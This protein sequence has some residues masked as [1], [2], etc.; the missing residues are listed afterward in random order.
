MSIT[1]AMRIFTLGS[2]ALLATTAAV[3]AAPGQP[4]PWQLGLQDAV[5]PVAREGTA[6]FNLL[7]W[8]MSAITLL[9]LGLLLYTLVRFNR[10]RNPVPSK[11]THNTTLEVLWTVVPV[12]ILLIIAVP[13][14]RLLYFADR[15]EEADMTLKVIGKQWYWTYEYPDDGNFTFDSLMLDDEEADAQGKIRLLDVDNPVVLPVDTNIR[16]LVTAGDV[17]HSFAVPSLFVKIDAVPGRVN[18][19]WTRIPAEYAGTT[20]YGQC[21]ELCGVNHAYM[22]VAIKA[23]SKAE[24]K[25]WVAQAQQE[26]A[27]AGSAAK[28]AV[29]EDQ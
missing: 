18:E 16:L 20:L 2:L 7:L 28:L 13:S 14:F 26:F 27:Q 25:A 29:L 4:E 21:S 11:V 8:L 23:V 1:H 24:Y 3:W 9:V 22:P 17:L 6:F 10:R 12:L 5:S 19:T 15:V